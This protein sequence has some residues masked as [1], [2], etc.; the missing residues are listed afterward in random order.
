LPNLVGTIDPAP[1]LTLNEADAVCI[2]LPFPNNPP[3][4]ASLDAANQDWFIFKV[5][6]TS[7]VSLDEISMGSLFDSALAMG[8]FQGANTDPDPHPPSH[9]G[10]G[11]DPL[12]TFGVLP[13]GAGLTGMSD[14]LFAAF[15]AGTF[16]NFTG[17]ADFMVSETGDAGNQTFSGNISAIQILPEPGGLL[18][19]GTGVLA[20]GWYFRRRGA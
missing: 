8:F 18:L 11:T 5:N 4:D 7:L 13:A 19:L 3:C 14:F 10:V 17:Q 2:D 16:P 1:T 6:I 15:P 12:W 9:P 20:V